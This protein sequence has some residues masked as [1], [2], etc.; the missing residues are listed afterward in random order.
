MQLLKQSL[1]EL[2]LITKSRGFKCYK[3]MSKERLLSVL[4]KPKLAESAKECDNERF[5]KIEKYFH[6]LRHSFPKPE[7]KE[8]RKIFMK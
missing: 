7:I 8:V 5:E 1:N 2:K 4:S 6:E 3:S